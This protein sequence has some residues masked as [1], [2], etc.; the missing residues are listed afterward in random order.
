MTEMNKIIK[1]LVP[2]ILFLT[3]F[4]VTFLI[5]R[6]LNSG[7]TKTEEGSF[8]VVSAVAELPRE[9]VDENSGMFSVPEEASRQEN[10]DKGTPDKNAGSDSNAGFDSE[11]EKTIEETAEKITN[12]MDLALPD[13]YL[14]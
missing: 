6:G 7:E 12:G 8:G 1:T 5:G 10:K 4:L 11:T 3:A 13:V 9:K 2:L 14:F